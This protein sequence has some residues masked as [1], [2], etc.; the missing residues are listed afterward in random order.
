M[1]TTVK[2]G[3]VLRYLIPS[4]FLSKEKKIG[5]GPNP[6]YGSTIGTPWEICRCKERWQRIPWTPGEGKKKKIN[7]KRNRICQGR[8]RGWGEI[9]S[10]RLLVSA[11]QEREVQWQ[12]YYRFHLQPVLWGGERHLRQQEECAW[13]HAAGREDTP[14]LPAPASHV[15]SRPRGSYWP[16]ICW[17]FSTTL[18]QGSAAV[19]Y[20]HRPKALL[21]MALDILWFIFI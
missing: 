19:S 11:W 20:S 8:E 15:A 12:L 6:K 17:R 16:P 9:Q 3:L 10:D 18:K 2:R 21:E 13:P 4:L 14:V 1:K 7:K 5:F